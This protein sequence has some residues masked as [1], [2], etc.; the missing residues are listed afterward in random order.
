M[1][2]RSTVAPSRSRWRAV[3]SSGSVALSSTSSTRSAGPL[4]ASV[5]LV[6]RAAPSKSRTKRPPIY[7]HSRLSSFEDCPRKFHYRYVLKIPQETEGIEAFVGKRVH[8]VLERLYEF[9]GR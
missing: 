6:A 3:S 2:L 1:D 8:E 5:T 4:L 9:V 7:S